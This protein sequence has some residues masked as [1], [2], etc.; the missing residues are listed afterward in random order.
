MLTNDAG[1][2]REIKSRMV[3]TKAA[4]DKKKALFTRKMD[5]NLRK[6]LVQCYTWSTAVCGVGTW[7]L[8]SQSRSEI[9]GKF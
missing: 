2:T 9:P 8:Q 1:C 4:F 7:T 6:K 3:M 5:L